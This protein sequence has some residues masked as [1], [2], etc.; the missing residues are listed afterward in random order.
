M[1]NLLQVVLKTVATLIPYLP[2]PELVYITEVLPLVE[3]VLESGITDE[4]AIQILD[5]SVPKQKND[6]KK[7]QESR[8]G[9]ILL[10][11]RDSTRVNVNNLRA[12]E[13]IY[14]SFHMG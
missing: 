9:S 8:M 11:A 10:V 3:F 7:W 1:G 2:M 14:L 6:D 13:I 12:P 5:L 4:D